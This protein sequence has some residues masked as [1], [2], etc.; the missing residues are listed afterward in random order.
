MF[1]PRPRWLTLVIFSAALAAAGCSKSAG[2]ESSQLTCVYEDAVSASHCGC[3]VAPPVDLSAG[4]TLELWPFGVH[5]ESGH[6]EGHRGLDFIST[7]V[8]SP[9][10]SPV[11]GVVASIDNAQDSSGG[12]AAEYILSPRVH[13]TTITADCGLRVVFIPLRLDD[14]IA[15]GTRVAKGQRL[16]VLPEMAAPYGPGR[17]S[18]HFEIDAGTSPND[19]ALYAV[20]PGDLFAAGEAATLQSMLDNSSYPEK[21]ARTVAVSCD[22]GGAQ[23]MTY[24]AEN[25]LC[26]PRLDA[27]SHAVLAS[28]VPSRASIIW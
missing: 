15:A 18:T 23:A 21:T 26:N 12:L 4:Q 10:Y 27:G 20:C 7:A 14:G 6:V 16:G 3:S 5:A 2:G 8:A 24:A 17:W 11:D 19:S 13:Y 1:S 22:S 25:L 9:I 28:C